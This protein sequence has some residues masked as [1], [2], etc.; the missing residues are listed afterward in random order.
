MLKE[1]NVTQDVMTL[2][3]D[4]M[5]DI[6]IFKNLVQHSLTKHIG[7]QHHFIQELMEDKIITLDHVSTEKQFTDIF[8]N[9]LD[10]TQF[11]KLRSSRAINTEMAR[12]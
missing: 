5:K 1:Y 8:T 11:K 9:A 2:Y 6:N 3:G 10:D 12:E 4:N 7:I